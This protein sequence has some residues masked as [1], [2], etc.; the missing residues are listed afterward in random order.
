MIG[1]L[2]GLAVGAV[3]GAAS[4][5]LAADALDVEP[6][7]RTNYRG[8][9]VVTGAGLVV[10]F[11]LMLVVVSGRIIDAGDHGGV[12]WTRMGSATLVAAMGFALFGFLDDVA[13]AGQSGGFRGHLA[14]LRHGR[15]T[16]GVLKLIGGA[17]V[18]VLSV[19]MLGQTESSPLGVV[20]DGATL[21]LAANL[22][23]LLDRAPG[24]T[25]KATS[26]TF[27][28]LAAASSDPELLA[29]ALVVG[30]GLGL[31]VPELRERLMLGDAGANVMGAM[32]AIA[33]LQVVH[34]PLHRW[35]LLGV[36]LGL[37]L[38]SEVV[39]FSSVIDAFG[40]LRWFDRLGSLRS[41]SGPP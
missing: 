30:A 26:V 37:N 6:L 17:V 12:A 39:S 27:L 3:M 9:Q 11:P 1:V 25:T 29:P 10:V 33:A 15:T 41:G 23:N 21:A 20:R 34:S 4:W 5:L 28:I 36:V 22:G 7:R 32:C 24:R 8:A 35:M 13:G 2:V 31:L 38:L 14:A 18:G 19:S 16:T 40:P